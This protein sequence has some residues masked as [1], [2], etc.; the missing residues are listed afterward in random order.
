VHSCF[1]SVS[2]LRVKSFPALRIE[3]TAD[4]L[5]PHFFR[6]RLILYLILGRRRHRSHFSFMSQRRLNSTCGRSHFTIFV[7]G[8]SHR[9]LPVGKDI[10]FVASF[11]I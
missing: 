9:S 6:Y 5:F 3:F 11:M 1:S 4:I 2:F 7:L 10:I 8:A